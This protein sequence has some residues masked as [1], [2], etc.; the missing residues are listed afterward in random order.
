MFRHHR[1]GWIIPCR[2]APGEGLH[3]PRTGTS[4]RVTRGRQHEEPRVCQPS[5]NACVSRISGA[6]LWT[7]LHYCRPRYMPRMSCKAAEPIKIY[8][9]QNHHPQGRYHRPLYFDSTAPRHPTSRDLPPRRAV[10]RQPVFCHTGTHF[11]SQHRG[12]A[13]SPASGRGLRLAKKNTD[14]QRGQHPPPPPFHPFP[15]SHFLYTD[16]GISI[17][18]KVYISLGCK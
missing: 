6:G 15:I 13:E 14:L 3:G 5:H 18:P 11:P 17:A 4:K 16:L 12:H 2:A 7:R 8:S 10:S 9:V 1:T